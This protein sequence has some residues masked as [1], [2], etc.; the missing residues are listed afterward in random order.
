MKEVYRHNERAV[1]TV[2]LLKRITG[3]DIHKCIRLMRAVREF[4]NITI[5][6]PNHSLSVI[7]Y[8]YQGYTYYTTILRSI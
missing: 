3:W 4:D 6:L 2:K 5:G 7:M 8:T 1:A